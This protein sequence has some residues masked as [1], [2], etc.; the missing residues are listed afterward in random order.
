MASLYL[1]V[2][3]VVYGVGYACQSAAYIQL[4]S[5]LKSCA[6]DMSTLWC[7]AIARTNQ[8]TGSSNMTLFPVLP[9]AV[10]GR[11]Y[12]WDKVPSVE[13]FVQNVKD[14][15]TFSSPKYETFQLGSS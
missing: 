1:Y 13:G 4:S 9:S 2:P 11:T 14:T 5:I 15:G 8:N 10:N 12:T 6:K 7:T 3:Q